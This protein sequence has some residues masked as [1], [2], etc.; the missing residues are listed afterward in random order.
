[1]VIERGKGIGATARLSV[2]VTGF[3]FTA[4]RCRILLTRR[5]DNGEWCLPGGRVEP[6][7]SLEDAVCREVLEETGLVVNVVRLLGASSDPD[8]VCAYPDGNRWQVVEIDF[9][10]AVVGGMLD[11]GAEVTDQAYFSL[12]EMALIDMLDG[13][14]ARAE[15]ALLH[16]HP[17][18]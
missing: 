4:D 14:G 15:R 17:V 18:P 1:V 12:S 2:A 10:C 8:S 11:G 13:E 7:E 6:G 5:A 9:E 3:I 16:A